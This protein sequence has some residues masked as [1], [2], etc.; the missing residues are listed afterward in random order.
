MNTHKLLLGIKLCL[1]AALAC[2]VLAVVIIPAR[3]GI[4]NSAS[5]NSNGSEKTSQLGDQ[6]TLT[7][8]D[9]T[10]IVKRNPFCNSAAK[11]NIPTVDN[12]GSSVSEQLKLALIGTVS[13]SKSISRAIIKSIITPP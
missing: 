9:Y 7:N 10:Q 12:S 2:V 8:N 13:G 3:S 6:N 1:T 11:T 4:P 5:A